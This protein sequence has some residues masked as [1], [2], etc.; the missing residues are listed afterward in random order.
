MM[1]KFFVLMAAMV[2][3]MAA[4]AQ[5]AVGTVSLKPMVGMTIAN[6]VG[7]DVEDSKM[8]VGLVAG[9]DLIYQVSDR[10]ALSGGLLYAMQG[11]KQDGV[12]DPKLKLDYLNV[13]L[14]GNLYV[15]KGLAL[16]AGLQLGFL[17]SAKAS[18]S[19]SGM[20][21]NVDVKDA[22]NTFDLSIPVG[23]SY[24]INNS[25]VIEGRYNFGMTK[26][27]KKSGS[28]WGEGFEA[29]SN[30]VRNSV[31]QLTLGYKFAL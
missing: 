25:F 22:F 18:A 20:S 15:A 3:T 21:A 16:K 1:K 29:E 24:D 10:F 2:M 19:D 11:C 14:L 23:I 31:I 4:N 8:K 12:G 26:I 9:A 13:P 27:M 30:D 5:D 17:M 7:D 28:L 6:V